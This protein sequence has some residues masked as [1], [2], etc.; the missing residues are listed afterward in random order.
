MALT[1]MGKNESMRKLFFVLLMAFSLA[2][3][4]DLH[5]DRFYYR[6]TVGSEPR[7]LE[8]SISNQELRG[9]TIHSGNMWTLEGNWAYEGPAR[10]SEIGPRGEVG[11]SWMLKITSSSQDYASTLTGMYDYGQAMPFN[12]QK[13]ADYVTSQISQSRVEATVQYPFFLGQTPLNDTVQTAA[14]EQQ[15][16]FLLEGQQAEINGEMFNG[17]SLESDYDIHYFSETVLSLLN[18]RFSYTGGTHPN[19]E[20]Q[21]MNVQIEK[22]TLSELSLDSFFS[23]EAL[24][25][26]SSYITEELKKQ[27]AAWIIDESVRL[28]QE[29]LS[30]FTFSPLGFNFY[31]P[32]YAVGPYAQGSFVVTLSPQI[33]EEQG[34]KSRLLSFIK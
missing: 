34:I 5:P 6:G 15:K 20:Y 16:I 13:V 33:L 31:F 14:L 2:T 30:L 10:L 24:L 22:S 32:P 21:V 17:W 27:H 4:Q 18:T 26:L 9:S 28:D 25:K 3:A 11:G 7:Q 1:L 12:L 29:L 23:E 19:T 8:L